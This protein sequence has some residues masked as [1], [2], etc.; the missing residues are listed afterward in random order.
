MPSFLN[1]LITCLSN[2]KCKFKCHSKCSKCME[3]DIEMQ[4]GQISRSNSKSCIENNKS[5]IDKNQN[6]VSV[7]SNNKPDVINSGDISNSIQ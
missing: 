6:Q 2:C 4:E 1:Q 3:L 5:I 7:I